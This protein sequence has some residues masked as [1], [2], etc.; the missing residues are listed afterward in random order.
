MPVIK[1]QHI[2]TFSSEDVNHPARNLLS[3]DSYRKW[4]CS[5]AGEKQAVVVL[6]LET[7][8]QIHSLDIGNEGSAFVELL[9]G[10]SSSADDYKVLLVAS[11]FMSPPDSKAWNN[12]NRALRSCLK[13]WQS[14]SGIE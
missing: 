1:I 12:T 11:T 14:R 5:S 2:S 13:Q 10:R 6:Q 3:S 7:P 4:K 9:V 8:I